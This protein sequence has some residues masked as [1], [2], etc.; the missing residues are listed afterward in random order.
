LRKAGDADCQQGCKRLSRLHQFFPNQPHNLMIHY[1]IH[2]SS[3]RRR[4]EVN[5][6]L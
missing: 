5:E 1:I 6:M 4:R 3:S 2:H